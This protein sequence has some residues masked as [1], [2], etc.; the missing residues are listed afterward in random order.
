MKRLILKLIVMKVIQVLILSQL[1]FAQNSPDDERFM[2]QE[3]ENRLKDGKYE[4][5][6]RMEVR[7]DVGP[8]YEG[9]NKEEMLFG[10]L[11]PYIEGEM[12]PAQ[13]KQYCSNMDEMADIV[14]SKVKAKIGEIS[15]V[16][17]D[18][19]KEE[20]E[21]KERSSQGCSMMG[22]PDT[23]YAIDE[24]HKFEILSGSCPVNSDAIKQACILRMNQNMEDRL[25]Y[26]EENC[27]NQWEMNGKQNQQQCENNKMVCEEDDYIENCLSR[28]GVREDDINNP[29]QEKQCAISNEE[30]ERKESACTASNGVPETKR[31][32]DCV[33]QVECH[34]NPNASGNT[35]TGNVAG[36]FSSYDDAK[37]QCYN[38]W[39]YQKQNCE[40][41]KNNC[42]GQ[43]SFVSECVAREKG[44]AENNMANIQ[45][46]CDMDSRIQIKHMER[47]CA[48][49][50]AERRR[51]IDESAK[52]CGMMEG[53]ASECSQ[54]VTEENF[55]N[56]IIREAEKRCKFMPFM[57][58]K[59][60]SKYEKIEVVLA[61]LDTVSEDEIAK[62]SSIVENLE[63][64]YEEKGKIIFEGTMKPS[65]FGNLK[66]LSFVVGAKLNAPE[67]SETAKARKESIIAS[68]DPKKVVE[69]LLEL[70][71]ADVS[72]EYKYIIEDKANDILEASESIEDVQESEESKGFGYKIKLFLGFAKETEEGEIKNLESSKQRL[73]TSIRSLGKL[74]E[75]IPDEISKAI[76]KEQVAEL[77]RQ[78]EDINA[79]IKQKQRK[80]SGLLRLFG[81]FG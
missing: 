62:I 33:V 76:L 71:D 35:I 69:K 3:M 66:A 18:M 32:G 58:K 53:L 72:D 68:L 22:Q 75:E 64:K 38:E 7:Y 50:D 20:L 70:R 26:I 81:L 5:R 16:C 2:K 34:P 65:D 73:E 23:R 27:K 56:F 45:R 44:F 48:M 21:C 42:K 47:Q 17:Q 37:R 31:E 1:V 15:N 60:L 28:Y 79:L 74:A 67:S 49:M 54:K 29:P 4:F 10:R 51:C 78:K 63:K 25:Q 13:I 43:D 52:R 55:R 6:E 80:A 12:D 39:Q 30:A 19:E 46:Q 40:N 9:F 41:I 59:D 77:E 24:L 57:E 11:F 8:S 36:A 14:I 61:V